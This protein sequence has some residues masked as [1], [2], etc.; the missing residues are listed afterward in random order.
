MMKPVADIVSIVARTR[1][2]WADQIV[3]RVLPEGEIRFK[4]GLVEQALCDGL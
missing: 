1:Q 3:R 4:S 2:D